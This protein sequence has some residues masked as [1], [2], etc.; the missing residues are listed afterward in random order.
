MTDANVSLIILV[1]G[2]LAFCIGFAMGY[3]TDRKG[4]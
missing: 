2:F 3:M 1:V 4:R